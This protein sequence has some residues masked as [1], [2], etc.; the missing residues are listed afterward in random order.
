MIM[1]GVLLFLDEIGYIR[2][3]NDL[4]SD[5]SLYRKITKIEGKMEAA[6]VKKK[7][8]AMLL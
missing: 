4:Q 6:R 8:K 1:M 2:K 3:M 7:A 5:A